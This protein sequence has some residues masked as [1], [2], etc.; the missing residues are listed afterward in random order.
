MLAVCDNGYVDVD[1]DVDRK[2]WKPLLR[3]E[4]VAVA[5]VYDDRYCEEMADRV[6]N[7]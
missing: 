1:S 6:V 7:E 4:M 3:S 5:V 2:S